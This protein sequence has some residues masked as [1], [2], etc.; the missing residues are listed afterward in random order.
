MKVVD[1]DDFKHGVR[2][3]ELSLNVSH[4][5]KLPNHIQ[6]SRRFA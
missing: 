3:A 6:T 2:V 5:L 1:L 4:L